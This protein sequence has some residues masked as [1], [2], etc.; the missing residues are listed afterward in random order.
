MTEIVQ[1]PV[2][3]VESMTANAEGSPQQMPVPQP[4]ETASAVLSTPEDGNSTTEDV[5]GTLYLHHSSCYELGT[6]SMRFKVLS[7]LAARFC[8]ILTRG[9]G[10]IHATLLNAAKLC[11]N[12]EESGVARLALYLHKAACSRSQE[13]LLGQDATVW[14]QARREWAEIFESIF[15]EVYV[16]EECIS[17]HVVNVRTKDAGEN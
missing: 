10:T 3:V 11:C 15:R 14:V 13:R 2:S 5:E 6:M 7:E 17:F 12:P 9:E 16:E 1:S 4:A 8:I